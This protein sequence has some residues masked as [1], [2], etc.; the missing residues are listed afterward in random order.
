MCNTALRLRSRSIATERGEPY[1]TVY[2]DLAASRLPGITL[3]PALVVA[4]NR[5]Q[6]KGFT[7]VR[8]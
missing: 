7:Y 2:K 3:V 1:D 5:A 8:V 4:L 6:E